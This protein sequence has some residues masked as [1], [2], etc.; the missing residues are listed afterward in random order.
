MPEG[1]ESMVSYFVRYSGRAADPA[2]F[3]NYYETMHA[4]I[5]ARFPGIRSL[6]LHRPVAWSDPFAVR[7]DRTSLLAQMTFDST[8]DLGRALQSDARRAAREDFFRFPQFEGEVTHQAMT[9]TV[10]I[11]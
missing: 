2:A 7:E 3:A 10:I 8:A 5:L 11:R 6:V 4:P 1:V 9:A